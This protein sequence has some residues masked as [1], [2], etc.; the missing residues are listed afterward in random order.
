MWRDSD[1]AERRRVTLYTAIVRM[2]IWRRVE[3]V[4]WEKVCFFLHIIHFLVVCNI[5]ILKTFCF[6]FRNQTLL[7][8]KTCYRIYNECF[9]SLLAISIYLFYILHFIRVMLKKAI[10]IL[11]ECMYLWFTG[12]EVK[13]LVTGIIKMSK[14]FCMH[15][16][17]YFFCLQNPPSQ[18]MYEI[19]WD[20]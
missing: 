3:T 18:Q 2:P 19:I 13:L 16:F 1:G 20:F 9:L 17:M 8:K 4:W 6:Y 10:N 11:L 7:D 12:T 5:N 14:L 15:V